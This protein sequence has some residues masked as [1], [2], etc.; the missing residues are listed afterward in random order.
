MRPLNAGDILWGLQEEGYNS[1]EEI[2]HDQLIPENIPV[3]TKDFFSMLVSFLFHILFYF[4]FG[5]NWNCNCCSPWELYLCWKKTLSIVPASLFSHKI[6]GE[7]R[8]TNAQGIIPKGTGMIS[9]RHRDVPIKIQF[10]FML[11]FLFLMDFTWS[12]I[13]WYTRHYPWCSSSSFYAPHHH[14]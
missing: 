2:K 8:T 3:T 13:S 12:Y 10:L 1:L 5:E 11:G 14:K 7:D 6:S 4:I 9:P